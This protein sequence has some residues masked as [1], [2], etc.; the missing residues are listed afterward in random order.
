MI[1]KN[2]I[3]ISYG[4]GQFRKKS[5][6]MEEGMYARRVDGIDAET[7]NSQKPHELPDEAGPTPL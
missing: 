3:G 1:K 4:N 7:A 6:T 2:P 5:V